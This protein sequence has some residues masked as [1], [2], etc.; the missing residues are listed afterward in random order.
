MCTSTNRAFAQATLQNAWVFAAAG[1]AA[2]Y[3]RWY[4]DYR[5]FKLFFII[6]AAV[7]LPA[8]LIVGAF[9][10][11][12]DAACPIDQ[13]IPWKF[14]ARVVLAFLAPACF[15]MADM[16]SD[17]TIGLDYLSTG[18]RFLCYTLEDDER[19][20]AAAEAVGRR[21]WLYGQLTLALVAAVFIM[22]LIVSVWILWHVRSRQIKREEGSEDTHLHQPVTS[23]RLAAIVVLAVAVAAIPLLWTWRSER[24]PAADSAAVHDTC[25]T[26][27]SRPFWWVSSVL[28][29]ILWLAVL[30]LLMIQKDPTPAHDLDGTASGMAR[31]Q[32][33]SPAGSS[34]GVQ[35]CHS[36]VMHAHMDNN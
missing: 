5:G 3:T 36:L 2:G 1:R 27:P 9:P 30:T 22:T 7:T 24:S 10:I 20:S 14:R 12:T 15:N 4:N 21:Y 19:F 8:A 31:I 32:V 34:S 11:F 29:T 6:M 26:T 18:M 16:V 35:V 23:T 13:P 25:T 17:I 33:G 28:F